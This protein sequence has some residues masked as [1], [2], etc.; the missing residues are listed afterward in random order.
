M[1]LRTFGSTCPIGCWLRREHGY[2][3]LTV[4]R[5]RPRLAGGLLS[6]L[7]G[8]SSSPRSTRRPVRPTAA[9]RPDRR[10]PGA[11]ACPAAS[12]RRRYRALRLKTFFKTLTGAGRALTP[13]PSSGP[14][15]R[16]NAQVYR[17]TGRMA[18]AFLESVSSCLP[19]D[20]TRHVQ[21]APLTTRRLVSAAS[22]G[23][24]VQAINIAPA[25]LVSVRRSTPRRP[26]GRALCSASCRPRLATRN[27]W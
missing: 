10:W 16:C 21:P 1:L 11:A 13:P 20:R 25:G 14:A 17:A 9:E 3:V 27:A 23:E 15:R 5:G 22:G 24:I 4:L 8:W 7:G 19:A 26:C 18:R 6:A 12:R 2:G